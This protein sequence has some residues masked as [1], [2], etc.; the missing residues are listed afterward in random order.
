M[1]TSSSP[2]IVVNG[3]VVVLVGHQASYGQTRI[4]NVPGDIMGFDA[5]TGNSS[6]SSTSSRGP[7]SSAT[8]RGRN[9]AWQWSEICRRGLPHPP[10]RSW[11]SCT[12]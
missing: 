5:R 10:T 2:P 7:A 12:S 9:D 4:E 1:V 11:G 6:G 3:V 8:R